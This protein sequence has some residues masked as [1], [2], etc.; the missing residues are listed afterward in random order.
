MAT[1]ARRACGACA[2]R[3][4]I[5]LHVGKVEGGVVVKKRNPCPA[6]KWEVGGRDA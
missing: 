2:V 4:K 6:M 3:V 5:V 1:A